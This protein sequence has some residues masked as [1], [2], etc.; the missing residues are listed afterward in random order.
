MYLLVPGCQRQLAP[1]RARVKTCGE[2]AASTLERALNV[3]HQETLRPEVLHFMYKIPAS[4]SARK[5]KFNGIASI[6]VSST[7]KLTPFSDN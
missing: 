4:G 2:D 1:M 7:D 5:S 3:S 6:Q